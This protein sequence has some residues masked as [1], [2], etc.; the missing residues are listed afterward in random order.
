MR[1]ALD[2]AKLHDEIRGNRDG[3][4]AVPVDRLQFFH[5]HIRPKT[6]GRHIDWSFDRHEYLQAIVA[7][8]ARSIVCRKGTQVGMSTFSV[9]AA[10]HVAAAHGFHVGYYLPTD[11]FIKNFVQGRFDPLIDADDTL[12]QLVTE[13]DP[14]EV[15]SDAAR[16]RRKRADHVEL[17][18]IGRGQLWFQGCENMSDVISIDLDL[19]VLDEVDELDQELAAF[20]DDRIMHSAYARRIAL[21]QPSVP[22]FGIDAEYEASDQKHWQLRCAR[23][24]TWTCLEDSFPDCLVYNQRNKE[25]RLVCIRCGARLPYLTREDPEAAE[26]VAEYPGREVSGYHISQLYGPFTTADKVAAAW[27]PAQNDRKK[28][29]R[30]TISF[31]GYGF[32]GDRQPVNE[33][34]FAKACKGG[35]RTSLQVPPEATAVWAGIDVGDVLHLCVGV[36]LPGRPLQVPWFEEVSWTTLAKRLTAF[37]VHAFV[38]DSRPEKTKAEELI[39]SFA[40]QGAI[41]TFSETLEHPIFSDPAADEDDPENTDVPYIKLNRT[42]ALDSL[43]EDIR[44]GVIKLPSAASDVMGEVKRHFLN[45]V[46]DLNERDLTYRYRRGVKNHFALAAAYMRLAPRA[47]R[48][49]ELGP[50]AD[51]EIDDIALDREE[52]PSQW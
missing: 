25:W 42:D 7:D 1:T 28:R 46:K 15:L 43:C 35:P 24:R 4:L 20:I 21:S 41:C 44:N 50:P 6:G 48:R 47:A 19:I 12:A 52:L 2:G 33:A 39:R 45:L 11:R 9:G 13:G 36:E 22:G 14:H 32:A 27:Q 37:G 29:E 31:R 38:I 30:F 18:L 16:K 40:H 26:W 17:K 34:V 51:F 49:L 8:E 3:R 10:L 23:C 5:D